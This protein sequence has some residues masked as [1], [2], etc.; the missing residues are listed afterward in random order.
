MGAQRFARQSDPVYAV[1][2]AEVEEVGPDD[3]MQME[4]LMSVGMV[5]GQARGGEAGELRLHFTAELGLGGARE[6]VAQAGQERIVAELAVKAYQGRD[7]GGRQQRVI[8]GG[9]DM[10]AD[11]DT[12]KVSGDGDGLVESRFRD[13]QAGAG[14]DALPM[15]PQDRRVDTGGV[16]EIVRIDDQRFG[17]DRRTHE[18]AT[19]SGG[20]VG[21]GGSAGAG[22]AVCAADSATGVGSVGLLPGGSGGWPLEMRRAPRE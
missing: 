2:A 9:G 8:V 7:L 19:R 10:E 20:V 14:E 16:A 22:A 6:G 15:R 3:G 1:L 11:A 5:P 17:R 4:V 12:R 13:H 18:R 21:V